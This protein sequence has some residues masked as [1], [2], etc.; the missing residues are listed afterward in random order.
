MHDFKVGDRVRA[1]STRSSG[2]TVTHEF[3]VISVGGNSIQSS[4]WYFYLNGSYADEAVEY[5]L[6]KRAPLAEPTNVGAVVLF[7]DPLERVRQPATHIGWG[8]WVDPNMKVWSWK[9]IAANDCVVLGP[10][11]EGP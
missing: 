7:E 1:V 10:G 11:V 9:V 3:T 4:E 5:T 6:L 2:D 8:R